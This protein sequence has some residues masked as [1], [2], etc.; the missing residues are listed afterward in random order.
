MASRLAT[1]QASMA[2]QQEQNQKA[3]GLVNA[4]ILRGEADQRT[5][6]MQVN[7][8]RQMEDQARFQSMLRVRWRVMRSVSQDVV[9]VKLGMATMALRCLAGEMPRRSSKTALYLALR[10][11]LPS[12]YALLISALPP[13]ALAQDRAIIF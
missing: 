6:S 1:A 9:T 11:C 8:A 13:V 4:N 2:A 3:A 12:E 7:V 10:L 5:R